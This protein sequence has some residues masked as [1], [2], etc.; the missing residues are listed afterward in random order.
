MTDSEPPQKAGLPPLLHDVFRVRR[1][2]LANADKSSP[3]PVVVTPAYDD[4][5]GASRRSTGQVTTAMPRARS[6]DQGQAG[7]GRNAFSAYGERTSS[8][9][10]ALRLPDSIDLVIRQIAAEQRTHPLRI[11]DRALYEHLVRLGRL[12]Q[13]EDEQQ[14]R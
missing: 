5:V 6:A 12:P 11:V 7:S 2:L 9:P 4:S 1:T 8:R 14:R 10:Y 3:R 13:P